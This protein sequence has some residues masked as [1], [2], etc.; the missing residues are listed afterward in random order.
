MPFKELLRKRGFEILILKFGLL[1][2][3]GNF[4][5][6]YCYYICKRTSKTDIVIMFA[7][8]LPRQILKPNRNKID[9]SILIFTFYN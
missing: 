8:E 2:L 6:R 9:L 4:Q 5:D 3:Q 7:R 1:C